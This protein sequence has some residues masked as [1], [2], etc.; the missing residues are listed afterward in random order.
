MT[1]ELDGLKVSL[2]VQ[3]KDFAEFKA[4]TQKQLRYFKPLPKVTGQ[5]CEIEKIE[6]TF[7]EKEFALREYN[8]YRDEVRIIMGPVAYPLDKN[9]APPKLKEKLNELGYSCIDIFAEVGDVDIAASREGLSYDEISTKRIIKFLDSIDAKVQQFAQQYV[10]QAQSQWDAIRLKS[11]ISRNLKRKNLLW[12]GEELKSYIE[13]KTNYLVAEPS[14]EDWRRKNLKLGFASSVHLDPDKPKPTIV[15]QDDKRIPLYR[16][17]R[18]NERMLRELDGGLLVAK[19]GANLPKL[20]EALDRAQWLNMSELAQAPKPVRAG[21]RTRARVGFAKVQ[22]ASRYGNWPNTVE[23]DIDKYVSESDVPVVWCGRDGT[24]SMKRNFWPQEI[25]DNAQFLKWFD[26]DIP[27]ILGIMRSSK[28]VEKKLTIPHLE[29]WFIA[30][31]KEHASKVDLRLCAEFRRLTQSAG[32]RTE[33][34]AWRRF[35]ALMNN[36]SWKKYLV[37]KDKDFAKICQLFASVPGYSFDTNRRYLSIYE[38]Y[39]N[40]TIKPKTYYIEGAF[41]RFRKRFELLFTLPSTYRIE[42]LQPYL[43]KI[44]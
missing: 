38:T 26:G 23:I 36:S 11:A 4:A 24:A 29:D 2:A 40:K 18:H 31:L 37:K 21:K 42:Q 6:Y 12:N 8:Y 9:N 30:E 20:C 14:Y 27:S 19:F 16:T 35:E 28:H 5:E 7:E 13:V 1:D 15:Y 25:I 22:I 43:D 3:H 44:R 32:D 41:K 17:L 34:D 10:D 33:Y 39:L